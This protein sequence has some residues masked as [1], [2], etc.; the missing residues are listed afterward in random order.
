MER[1]KLFRSVWKTKTPLI[2]VAG[3]VVIGIF[4]LI[5]YQIYRSLTRTRQVSN[6]VNVE[7]NRRI[8]S[9]WT[10][11]TVE[12]IAGS[13]YAMAPARSEQTYEASYYEKDASAVRNYLFV[14]I[15]D[16]S[17]RWLVAGNKFLFLSAVKLTPADAEDSRSTKDRYDVVQNSG[18]V[19]WIRYE[20]VTT[21][22]NGDNR[23]TDRDRR[24]VA[25][26]DAS[27]EGYTEVVRDVD[28]TL[29]YL[30]R[31]ESTLLVFYRSGTDN[32]VA[33]VSL[34]SRQITYSKA[35]PKIEGE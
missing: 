8:E 18:P 24:T 14:N 20:V 25:V 31:D 34:P 29:G 11:G 17:S 33:E 3:L 19:R 32:F 1:E 12:R 23:L 27:G 10:L 16:K 28:E 2:V 13:D 15:V 30:L 7:P 21:D 4:V 35:L 9:S 5:G 22:T 26:S 6:V